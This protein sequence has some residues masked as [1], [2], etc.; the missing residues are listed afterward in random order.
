[1]HSVSPSLARATAR[2]DFAQGCL[3][4]DNPYDPDTDAYFIWQ[5][6]MQNLI[7]KEEVEDLYRDNLPTAH[8]T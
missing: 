8:M 6:E 2:H 4:D 5:E 7:R 3:L 1:M